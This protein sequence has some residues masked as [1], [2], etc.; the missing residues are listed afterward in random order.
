M[1][2]LK[3]GVNNFKRREQC[4]QCGIRKA[5]SDALVEEGFTEVGLIPSDSEFPLGPLHSPLANRNGPG[6]PRLS[7]TPASLHG[8]ADHGGASESHASSAPQVPSLPPGHWR[9]RL[10]CRV[11]LAP[12]R[13]FAYV[14]M[15]SA[16][17][18]TQ[19]VHTLTSLTK[20]IIDGSE[21][22]P[23]PCTMQRC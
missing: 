10:W 7:P 13:K 5:E 17:E 3:C 19:V 11:N 2:G 1:W 8:G 15:S 23:V 22:R 18:A 9:R 16:G 6:S 4:F 14:Q 12:S 20:L 21:S